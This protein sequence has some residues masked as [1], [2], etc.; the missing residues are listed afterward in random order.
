M[1]DFGTQSHLQGLS[2]RELLFENP[3]KILKTPII[4]PLINFL[5]YFLIRISQ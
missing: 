4:T 3:L 1:T 2:N 5:F